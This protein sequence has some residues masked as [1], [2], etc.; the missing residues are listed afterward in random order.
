LHVRQ[1]R[2]QPKYT[3]L[4]KQYIPASGMFS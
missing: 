4:P 3:T 1:K 2:L